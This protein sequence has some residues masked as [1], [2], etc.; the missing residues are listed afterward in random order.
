MNRQKLTIFLLAL[1][2]IGG[3]A[4]G[5]Q[6]LKAGQ[7]LGAP[8]IKT[9]PIPGRLVVNIYLPESVLDYHSVPLP[10][11]KDA[12][13]ILP[14]DTS[15]GQRLYTSSAGNQLALDVVLMGTDRTS[16]HKPQF[17]LPGQG[18]NIDAGESSLDTVLVRSPHPYDLQVMRLVTSRD[19][20]ENGQRVKQSGIY[21]YWFVADHE[22]TADHWTRMRKMAAHLLTTGE[23]QR[24]AYVSCFTV[25]RPGNEAV[26][27]RMMKE[28]IAAAVPEFQ[29]AANP[30]AGGAKPEQTA[31]LVP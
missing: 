3:A 29:L 16:I 14:K 24:W 26:T 10:T 12:E 8:G 19:F 1:A 28:F 30:P 21:V 18:W 5:M 27:Y 4:F 17:C 9:S 22:L 23:L 31:A 2:L 25:C 7:K 11:S 15:F 6:R 13:A 20:E